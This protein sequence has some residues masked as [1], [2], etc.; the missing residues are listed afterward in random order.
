[1]N[2]NSIQ[3]RRKLYSSVENY[4]HYL[5][6]TAYIQHTHNADD[7]SNSNNKMCIISLLLS[8]YIT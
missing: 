5:H 7:N 2:E 3:A 1:M 6:H 4:Y 8:C